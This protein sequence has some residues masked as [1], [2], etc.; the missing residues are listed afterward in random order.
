[1][2]YLLQRYY[3]MEVKI[4]RTFILALLFATSAVFGAGLYYDTN[5]PGHGLHMPEDGHGAVI[6]F[7]NTLDGQPEWLISLDNCEGWPCETTMLQ[8]SGDYMS[9][10]L[11]SDPVGVIKIYEDGDDLFLNWDLVDWLPADYCNTGAGGLI[12]RKCVG[13]TRLEQLQ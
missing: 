10:S 1:M 6:W 13:T 5:T 3:Y 12:L 2:Q 7:L 9:G 8:V 11:D 4:M